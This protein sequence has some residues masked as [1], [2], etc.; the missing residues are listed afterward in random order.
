MFFRWQ[1][2]VEK[3][4]DA[5]IKRLTA[6]LLVGLFLISL[7]GCAMI[8]GTDRD[9]KFAESVKANKETFD[10]GYIFDSRHGMTHLEVILKDFRSMHKFWDRH[11]MNYDWDDPYID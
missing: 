6:L 9:H 7:T 2:L 11:F 8:W 3:Q 10:D 5:M 1:D 4:E